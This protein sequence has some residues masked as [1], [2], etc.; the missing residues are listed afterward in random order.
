MN[1]SEL[2]EACDFAQDL[3]RKCGAMIK[4]AFKEPK[5]VETKSS[6]VD[7]VTETDEAVEKVNGSNFLNFNK[8]GYPSL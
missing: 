6:A 8:F 4:K 7:L 5:T 2:S 1:E 3:A